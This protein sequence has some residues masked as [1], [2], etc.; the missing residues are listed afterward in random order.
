MKFNLGLCSVSFRDKTPSEIIRAIEKTPLTHVEWGSDV[1]LPVGGTVDSGS[2]K[3][4]SYGTYFRLGVSD[5][6][7][8]QGYIDT[9]KRVGTDTLR[10]WCGGESSA[11]CPDKKALFD[12]CRRA[13]EIA[14]KE[15]VTLCMECHA[16]TYTDTPESALELM[17]EVDSNNFKMYWQPDQYKSLEEN[18][19]SARLLSPYV[20]NVHVFN[21]DKDTRLPL[22]GARD[23]WKCYLEHFSGGTL[24]L[25]FMPD[26]RLDSLEREAEALYR[27]AEDLK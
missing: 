14:K 21:W 6:S 3:V 2:I 10:L 12:E 13:S 25:E 19:I 1:H 17:R 26:G 27:I 22:E 7:E 16:G 8:L 24:L 23:T 5:I 15:G 20:E 4:S 11:E 9:A 18:L